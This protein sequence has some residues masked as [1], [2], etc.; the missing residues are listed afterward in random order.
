MNESNK[1][2]TFFSKDVKN[3]NK[4]FNMTFDDNYFRNIGD[5]F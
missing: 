3:C 5:E 4:P 1:W 2:G